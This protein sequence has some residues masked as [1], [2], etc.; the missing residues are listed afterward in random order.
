MDPVTQSLL[1]A[2]AAQ[3]VLG[4]RLGPVAALIGAVGGEFPDIDVFLPIADAAL[5]MEY[6]R[7]FTHALAFI[8]FG[9]ALAALPFLARPRWR[10]QWK[11]IVAAATIGCATHGLLDT[12]T[13]YGTYL[14]WP[15]VNARLAWDIISIIDP[16]F[17]FALLVGVAWAV[18]ARS[19]TPARVA[20]VAACAYLAL[21][22]VQHHR[23]KGA[24]AMLA[25]ARGH[26]IQRGR[27]MPTLGNL[28]VWRSVYESNGR[29]YADAL[30]VGGPGAVLVRQ[31][32]SV[33]RAVPADLAGSTR[34]VRDVFDGLEAF[35]DGYVAATSNRPAT[36]GDMRYSMDPAG[37][38]PLWGIRIEDSGG[39]AD[40]VWIHMAGERPGAIR[41][42]W[43]SVLSA[44]GWAALPG[45]RRFSCI[46]DTGPSRK[47]VA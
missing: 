4:R 22:A 46:F 27:V 45:P 31:G 11:L 42:L 20:L 37:F 21:G 44:D 9:G 5:P 19:R 25:S 3:A 30:R 38:E 16:V 28:V 18:A 26:E 15:V 34:R 36:Y 24:Q 7:H 12:C 1:G 40:V 32:T 10:R 33:V 41:R 14:L 13:T 29:L 6:H 17:T 2:A 8:P 39:P 23:A 35:A 43:H 47:A